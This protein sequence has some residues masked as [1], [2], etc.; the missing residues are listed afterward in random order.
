MQVGGGQLAEPM[1]A[2]AITLLD[3]PGNYFPLAVSAAAESTA[4]MA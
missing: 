4:A 2:C 1:H 3:L